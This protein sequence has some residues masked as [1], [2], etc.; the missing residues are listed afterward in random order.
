M[1]QTD[2]ENS[3]MLKNGKK[4]LGFTYTWDSEH[5]KIP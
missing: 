5:N 1:Y 2:A 3:P 4:W